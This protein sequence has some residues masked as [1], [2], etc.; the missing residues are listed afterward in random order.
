MASF[1]VVM[2]NCAG[3]RRATP[4]TQGKVDYCDSSFYNKQ[5]SLIIFLESHHQDEDELPPIFHYYTQHYNLIHTPATKADTHTGIVV[6]LHKNYD[7]LHQQTI[8]DGRLIQIRCTNDVTGQIY[9]FSILYNPTTSDIRTPYIT[10]LIN[11]LTTFHTGFDRNFILGDFN[12]VD[13]ENDRGSKFNSRD[14]LWQ[15]Y[16]CNYLLNNKLCDPFR[17]N[18]PTKKLY[19]FVSSQ[20]KSRIDRLYINDDLLPHISHFTYTQTPHKLAHRVMSFSINRGLTIGPGYWKLNNSI[21]KDPAYA[22]LVER[23]IGEVDSIQTTNPKNWWHLFTLSIRS[24]SLTYSAKL[25]RIQNEHRRLLTDELLQLETIDHTRISPQQERRHTDVENQLKRYMERDVEGYKTRIKGLPTYEQKEPDI[26]FYANLQKK[27]AQKLY[28]SELKDIDGTLYTHTDDLIRI[29]TDYYTKLYTPTK[30]N[31]T[32]QDRLLNNITKRLSPQAKNSL[33]RPI[34]LEELTKAVNGMSLNKSPGPDGI[35]AEFFKKYWHLLQHKYLAYINEVQSSGLDWRY[36]TS[37]TTLIYKGK[38]DSNDLDNYRPISLINA[39]L[40]ILTKTLTNRLKRVLPSIIHHTQT[41]VQGR[42]IHHTVHLIRDL[43][44]YS[45]DQNIEACFLFLDREKAFD[46]VEHQ[47]LY[48]VLQAFGFGDTFINWIKLL[49]A[50]ATTRIKVN[51][52]LTTNIP[53]KR[54]ARQGDPLSFYEYVIVDEVLALQLRNNPNIVGFQIG[55]E[56]IV[57]AHYADDATIAILQNRCF[58]EVIKDLDD[59]GEASGSKLNLQKTKG[60]WTGPWTNRTDE[61]ISIKFTNKNVKSLGVYFGND[62]P[63]RDTFG[64]IVIKIRRTLNYWKPFALSKLAKARVIEIFHASRLWYAATFYPIPKNMRDELQKEFLKYID[65][66]GKMTTVSQAEMKRLRRDGGLKL[67]DIQTKSNASKVQ[68]LMSL[69][70]DPNLKVH[71]TLLDL[72]LGSHP[73]GQ[74]GIELFFT[75][76]TY[77]RTSLKQIPSPFYKEAIRAMTRLDALKKVSDVRDEKFF[78]NPIFTNSDHK[79]FYI[80]DYCKKN[81]ILTYGQLLDEVKLRSDGH[82]F[83]KQIVRLYDAITFTDLKDRDE[84]YLNTY[85][86]LVKFSGVTQ[87]LLYEE[88]LRSTSVDH[89]SQLK[90]VERLGHIEWG[91]VWKAIHNKITFEETRSKI[92]EQIHLN[93]YTTSSYNRWHSSTVPCPYCLVVPEDEF[94][95]ILDCPL[96]NSLWSQMEP[97]LQKIHPHPVDELEKVFGITGSTPS[98]QLRNFLTYILRESIITYE[99]LAYHNKLGMNNEPRIKAHLYKLFITYIKQN[100]NNF[101]VI[102]RPDLFEKYFF[103][104]NALLETNERG[105]TLLPASLI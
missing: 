92:W 102:G 90:W 104:N 16:W 24:A 59:F 82:P 13:H 73:G 99:R 55:G 21:L 14:K 78:Y 89:F 32:K 50:N 1:K 51:G 2:W 67:M 46:R 94:H 47:F 79:T 70:H 54:G 65:F 33:D 98:I 88:M 41:A 7:I 25:R 36:N 69:C 85:D 4:T 83:R 101:N 84:F 62:D 53:L 17:L 9:N 43:I 77:T 29:T 37:I 60:L 76:P 10:G 64:D 66:P 95:L 38:G 57:S 19:S 48:R 12:F 39:S 35:T 5:P 93:N 49:Q 18:N 20:G 87:K 103:I 71:K 75:T 6:L 40:K 91:Q 86:G 42:Q 11:H 96:T 34:T 80:S 15:K 72:L 28:I 56:K 23:V 105:E 8:I 27:T 74:V 97:L 44:Q 68:W 30:L 58:K 81:K 63:A 100:Y 26:Q 52:H 22:R 31:R 61:P 45:N 3:L